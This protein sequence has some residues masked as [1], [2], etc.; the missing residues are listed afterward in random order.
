MK[1]IDHETVVISGQFMDLDG[2]DCQHFDDPDKA[3]NQREFHYTAIR[4][5]GPDAPGV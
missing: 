5:P 1:L 3:L 4:A 2:V